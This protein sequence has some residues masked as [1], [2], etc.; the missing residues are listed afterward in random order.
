MGRRSE[1]AAIADALDCAASER[2]SVLRFVGG[3]GLGKTALLDHAAAVAESRGMRVIRL[4]AL[5]LEQDLPEAG[6]DILMRQF[7]SVTMPRTR[8][9]LLTALSDAAQDHPLVVLIDDV[10][11]LDAQTLAAV[12]FAT[13]RLMADS[14]AV[15]LA[16]RPESDSI[17]ALSPI[18]RLEVR[19]LD[20]PEGAALLHDVLPSVDDDVARQVSVALGGVP[21]ALHEAARILPP[22]ALSGREAIPDPVPVGPAVRDRYARG[23]ESLDPRSRTA[24]VLLATA[25]SVD[26]DVLS[27]AL[28]R[29]GLDVGDLE[30]AEEAG[31]V[32]LAPTPVFVHPLARSGVH[33]TARAAE[34]RAANEAFAVVLAERGDRRGALRHRAAA[35]TPPDREL[36]KELE[37]LAAGLADLSETRSEAAQF[38]LIAARFADGREDRSRLTVLAAEWGER[39]Q[40]VALATSLEAE[41]LAPDLRARATLVRVD[42]E[43]YPSQDA[44]LAALSAL[45]PLAL[46]AEVRHN[47]DSHRLDHAISTL[48]LATVRSIGTTLAR[49]A[50][51]D[52]SWMRLMSAGIALTFVGDHAHAVP[53]LRRARDTTAQLD[54]RP[55]TIDQVVS[56]ATLTGWLGED[57]AEHASR[58]RTLDSVFRARRQPEAVD[59]AA[60]FSA[61]RARREGHWDRAQAYFNESIDVA[62][63]AGQG[64]SASQVQLAV[65]LAHR[66][67]ETEA[68]ELIDL[69]SVELSSWSPWLAHWLAHARGALALTK[70]QHRQAVSAFKPVLAVSFVGRGA[71]DSIAASLVGLVEAALAVGEVDLA[72]RAAEDLAVRLDGVADPLGP[73]LVARCRAMVASDPSAADEQFAISIAEHDRTTAA[74]DRAR[75][76]LLRG[77]HLRRTRRPRLAR[78]P[79]AEALAE[80]ERFRAPDWGDRARRELAASGEKVAPRQTVEAVELT[81]QEARV[82]MA[83]ADGLTNAEVAEQL[84]L[85]VKT[86]EFHLRRIYRKLEIRSRSELAKA[87][88]ARNL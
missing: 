25:A 46:S 56:W 21:L 81:P 44:V 53:L 62:R 9:G 41:D 1:L 16:G 47:L 88:T 78:T 33:S 3:P 68:N 84:F 76:L 83:V 15:F 6:L 5:E 28:A 22:A 49:E 2:A 18:R 54:P 19:P 72:A 85:S 29:L 42:H 82:A 35:V 79:L 77:A 52:D 32:L 65:L 69:A 27:L 59:L 74:F 57:D 8:G 37:A 64:V 86:V 63:A 45:Q 51:A 11:W 7:G 40:A 43:A 87:L 13:R 38:A 67:Q 36:A 26:P 66:G 23:F 75:T 50:D 80:F 12:S 24:T 70:A 17:A 58:I 55:M 4:V 34:L 60:F 10:H 14:I 73:A 20:P 61:E 30:P 39:G 48:D 71:R 31:L